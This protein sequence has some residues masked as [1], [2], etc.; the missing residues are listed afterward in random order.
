[1]SPAERAAVEEMWQVVKVAHTAFTASTSQDMDDLKEA[2]A[3]LEDIG[4]GEAYVCQWR[5]KSANGHQRIL[6]LSRILCRVVGSVYTTL[7]SYYKLVSE[8]RDEARYGQ[9]A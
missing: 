9:Y 8:L 4:N 1:M 5:S 3:S 6:S 2:L 7:S